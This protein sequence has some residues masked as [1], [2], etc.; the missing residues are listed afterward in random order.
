MSRSLFACGLITALITIGCTKSAPKDNGSGTDPK[1]GTADKVVVP[2]GDVPPPRMGVGGGES[3][4]AK[5]GAEESQRLA[6]DE[7]KL[8]IE[9]PAD[10]KAGT[11]ATAK[12]TV[13]PGTGYHV[14][15]E[16]PTKLTLTAPEGITLAKAEFK[17]GGASKDKGDIDV[18]EESQLLLGVK[19]TAAKSGSYTING[20]FKFA[21]CDKD[22]CRPKKET[23]AIQVAVK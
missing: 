17:G 11:E 5:G 10:A 18:F 9:P 15:T 14:N 4:A 16:F 22:S 7:G 6:A 1:G 8:A 2:G 23:I 12:I 3:V 21:V 13:T 19:Y 20:T